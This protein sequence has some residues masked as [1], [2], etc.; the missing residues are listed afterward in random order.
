MT[1]QGN[2]AVKLHF[3]DGH[4]TGLFTWDYLYGLGRYYEEN[5][6]HYLEKLRAAGHERDD[7]PAKD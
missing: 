2:Y 7:G 3:D 6:A 1:P 5:W 4:D